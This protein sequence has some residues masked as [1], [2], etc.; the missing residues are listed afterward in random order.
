MHVS[1][2]ISLPVVKSQLYMQKRNSRNTWEGK[3]YNKTTI[4][5]ETLRRADLHNVSPRLLI[6][7]EM[8]S[9][10]LMLNNKKL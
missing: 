2:D 5:A 6:E 8:S 4:D 3:H 1:T 9:K 10:S 7:R